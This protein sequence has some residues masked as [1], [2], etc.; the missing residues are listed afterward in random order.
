MKKKSPEAIERET[1]RRTFVE[2]KL[3]EIPVISKDAI[4]SAPIVWLA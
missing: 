2:P 3:F 4:E 1:F